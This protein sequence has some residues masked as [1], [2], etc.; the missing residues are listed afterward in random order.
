MARASEIGCDISKTVILGDSAGGHLAASLA[1]AASRPTGSTSTTLHL[2]PGAKLKAQVLLCPVVTPFSP[3][4][5]HVRLNSG[6]LIGNGLITWMWVHYLPDPVRDM[7]NPRVSLLIDDDVDFAHALPP[8]VVVTAH[9]DPL[10]DEGDM[11]AE[12]LASK[13]TQVFAVRRLEAHCMY[14]PSTT[15]WA[16]AAAKALIHDEAVPT[17]NAPR[18]K[19]KPK[20]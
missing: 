8:T 15:D 1:F 2:P 11:L 10:C 17:I 9:F 3:T 19:P 12:R 13:G 18:W 16:F 20:P 7:A 4:G 5:S 14:D 6:P